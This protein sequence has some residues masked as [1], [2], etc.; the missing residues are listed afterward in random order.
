MSKPI[1]KIFFLMAFFH[2]LLAN[3]FNFCL[4]CDPSQS[5]TLCDFTQGYFLQNGNCIK[6]SKVNCASYDLTGNCLT[7]VSTYSLDLVTRNCYTVPFYST[8]SFCNAYDSYGNCLNC[9]P[10]YYMS[11]N[12]CL[13]VSQPLPNCYTYQTNRICS[14]CMTGYIFSSDYTLCLPIPQIS[15]CLAYSYL[16]C[17][18]C[19]SGFVLDPNKYSY[20][21]NNNTP[22]FLFLSNYL[23][24]AQSFDWTVLNSC[25]SF[26]DPNCLQATSYYN[27]SLCRNGYYVSNQATCVSNPVFSIPG[28]IVYSDLYICSQCTQ[29]SF[30]ASSTNC[31]TVNA[32]ANCASYNGSLSTTV[33][34]GC[35]FGFYNSNNKC[36]ARYYSTAIQNCQT[37]SINS[38]TCQ[39]CQSGYAPSTDGLACYSAVTNCQT[40][41]T[42]PSSVPALICGVCLP[43]YYP[44]TFATAPNSCVPG[45]IS[46]CITYN[47]LNGNC[48][49]CQNKFYLSNNLCVQQPT[50][51]SCSVYS[52]ST[53][54]SCAACSAGFLPFTVSQYCAAIP[55]INACVKYNPTLSKI[56]LSC[57]AN[58][59]LSVDSTQCKPIPANATNCLIY[60]AGNSSCIQCTN[61]TMLV[62]FLGIC[63]IPYDYI[64]EN[65]QSINLTAVMSDVS[66]NFPVC[67]ACNNNCI[68]R[69]GN[70]DAVCV[71]NTYLT[72]RRYSTINNCVRY[73]ADVPFRC[74]ECAIGFFVNGNT[75]YQ[76]TCVSAC[77]SNSALVLDNLDGYI[78][79]CI[80][81]TTISTF[82][83]CTY[84]LRT[85]ISVSQSDSDYQCTSLNTNFFFAAMANP[86]S[87]INEK[88]PMP[89]GSSNPRPSLFY[90]NGFTILSLSTSLTTFQPVP[91]C[92]LYYWFPLLNSYQCRKCVFG[93]TVQVN[94]T[95]QHTCA[96]MP[97]GDCNLNVVFSGY[98]SYIESVLS[99][100]QCSMANKNLRVPF[101]HVSW[102]PYS[103]WSTLTVPTVSVLSTIQCD[104]QPG[105]VSLGFVANCAVYMT[106]TSPTNVISIY[107]GACAPG[108]SQTYQSTGAN[109]V[110]WRVITC[111][112]IP[113]CDTSANQ[114]LVNKCRTCLQVLALTSTYSA[115]TD[116]TMTTCVVSLAPNCWIIG[117]YSMCSVCIPGFTLTQDYT[118]DPFTIPQCA[119]KTSIP[120]LSWNS[121]TLSNTV[122]QYYLNSYYQF[123]GGCQH[124]NSG[125]TRVHLS[126][127]ENYCVNSPYITSNAYSSPSAYVPNC[128]SYYVSG[129]STAYL[130]YTCKSAY[131]PTDNFRTCVSSLPNCQFVNSLSISACSICLPNFINVAGSC[132]SPGIP[133]CSIYGDSH[134]V[135]AQI[136]TSCNNGFYLAG[137]TSCYSG[138]V[139]NCLAYQNNSPNICF[140]CSSGYMNMVL[141]VTGVSY[142]FLIDP[143][144]VCQTADPSTNAFMSRNLI[145]QSC[146]QNLNQAFILTTNAIPT[147]MCLPYNQITNCLFYQDALLPIGQNT[148]TCLTCVSNYYY[149]QNKNACF[150]RSLIDSFCMT[151][152]NFSDTCL[153][154]QPGYHLSSS[155]FGCQQ[156]IVGIDN[157]LVMLNPSVC[158]YCFTG[159]YVSNNACLRVQLII[160]NCS[161]YAYSNQCLT[162]NPGF[163]LNSFTNCAVPVAANCLTFASSR[164]CQTCNQNNGLLTINGVTNCVSNYVPYCINATNV[165]PFVCLNCYGGYYPTSFGVCLPVRFNITGCTTYDSDSTCIRCALGGVLAF[166]RTAC[167]FFSFAK[168]IDPNCNN[169]TLTGLPY[170]SICNLGYSFNSFGNCVPQNALLTYPGC[171]L[172]S[173][174]NTNNCLVCQ[175]GF[176]QNSTGLCVNQTVGQNDASPVS[177]TGD[178]QTGK[179]IIFKLGIWIGL[180]MI[181]KWNVFG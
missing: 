75:G 45:T 63:V 172:A 123:V 157:C 99:C 144:Q 65:C 8:V 21:L 140:Q 101:I 131:T 166:N 15:N 64:L 146:V 93:F 125:Y 27:C 180:M 109:I 117:T 52:Q 28:C 127:L 57:A 108:Y 175:P 81:M 158:K 152:S 70:N 3:C 174:S 87:M 148:F 114:D 83:G 54:N 150:A 154:C 4:S 177:Q 46:N 88:I 22:I 110:P 94:Y 91:N 138:L 142:C 133:N 105:S 31:Q 160:P 12:A 42:N 66:T 181:S 86:T 19:V 112:A 136:C 23:N 5:C 135:T 163:Y 1:L 56:C 82:L 102:T 85:A 137:S 126:V 169:V 67:L 37:V 111:T 79:I 33:C 178:L 68:P 129:F 34:I 20:S 62:Q 171:L 92:L 30:L 134:L 18:S 77:S 38:D 167:D 155:T 6:S 76:N 124:C 50:I 122:I 11:T 116:I 58:Y 164:A 107:C 74:M 113:L 48:V 29:G 120:W 43:G 118:C 51:Q 162:C 32:I 97:S 44:N 47:Q 143:T 60:N 170:C 147:S 35:N 173:P 61:S 80:P 78:N 2:D 59:Y 119:S 168:K 98:P 55:L 179:A 161:I 53:A 90:H 130:C 128:L 41:Q 17:S 159:Y 40:Y 13:L 9:A 176:Y 106:L 156:I 103:S 14:A 149:D 26:A 16:S 121:Q 69:G 7:C 36:L 132:V 96:P 84:L 145:C 71:E 73:S 151:Y 72:F 104:F 165:F 10:G 25:Q 100:H 95:N 39:I 89:F 24:Q 49:Q 139:A 115:F 141:G 153:K